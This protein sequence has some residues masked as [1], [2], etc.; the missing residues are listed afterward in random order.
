MDECVGAKRLGEGRRVPGHS[1]PGLLE[2]K[3]RYAKRRIDCLQSP[4][5]VLGRPR[6][7]ILVEGAGL[8]IRAEVLNGFFSR[9]RGLLGSRRG[10]ARARAALFSPCSSI[11]TCGMRYPIDVAM[12][13]AWG[14][15]VCSRRDVPSW[16]FVGCRSAAYVLERPSSVGPWPDV[17]DVLRLKDTRVAACGLRAS[18]TSRM[19]P[20]FGGRCMG[21]TACAMPASG[22]HETAG[23]R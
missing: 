9:L 4:R 21:A 15:V 10:D 2:G 19:R 17:G 3:A 14:R 22:E 18:P 20:D 13:D 16:R 1:T 12:V 23:S 8:N 7:E 6:R 11:H 5:R